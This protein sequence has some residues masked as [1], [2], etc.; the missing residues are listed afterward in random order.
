[1]ERERER[2]SWCEQGYFTLVIV[3]TLYVQSM[4]INHVRLLFIRKPTKNPIWIEWRSKGRH[5]LL[6]HLLREIW[7]IWGGHISFKSKDILHTMKSIDVRVK[8]KLMHQNM[9]KAFFHLLTMQPPVTGWENTFS[10]E[11]ERESIQA[12]L[13]FTQHKNLEIIHTPNF[14]TLKSSRHQNQ[15]KRLQISLF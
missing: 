6:Y 1:M 15:L 11:K 3:A 5:F 2:E 9:R 4:D 13:S 8:L 14:T 7:Q 10:L 12:H